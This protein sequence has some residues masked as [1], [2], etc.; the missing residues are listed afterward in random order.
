MNPLPQFVLDLLASPPQAGTGI[1]RWMFNVA[2]QLHAHRSQQDIFQLLR[3]TLCDCGRRVPDREIRDAV[4]NSSKVAWRPDRQW[5]D[6]EPAWPTLDAQLRQETINQSGVG[7]YDLWERSPLRFED[8]LSHAEEILPILFP[9]EDS[10]ICAAVREARDARTQAFKQWRGSFE[11]HALIVPSPMRAAVGLT[12]DGRKSVRCR[13]NAGPRRF[14]VVEF[15]S[16]SLDNHAALLWQVA[17]TA[18]LTLAVFSGGKSLH[19]W[20]FCQGQDEGNLKE[21]MRRVVRLGADPATWKP[22]QMV[23]MPGGV[24]SSGEAQVIYY[25]NPETIL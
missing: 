14:L 3:T 23:R 2:R 8:N 12:I 7:L 9:D 16:G 6:R 19:G 18:P 1:H 13:D 25:F 22:E 24:R 17:E 4:R 15:D 20:F 21:F 5:T 11:Q 10:L